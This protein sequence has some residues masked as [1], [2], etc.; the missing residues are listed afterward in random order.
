MENVSNS[1]NPLWHL[2]IV[3][4]RLQPL[5]WR[6]S[7]SASCLNEYDHIEIVYWVIFVFLLDHGPG[8]LINLPAFKCGGDSVYQRI[9]PGSMCH[10]CINHFDLFEFRA[11]WNDYS[12]NQYLTSNFNRAI[13]F[14]SPFASTM[15]K[16]SPTAFAN[17]PVHNHEGPELCKKTDLNA[18]VKTWLLIDKWISY[19]YHKKDGKQQIVPSACAT[20]IHSMYDHLVR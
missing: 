1:R 20:T 8:T 11:C 2:A 19:K 17:F 10:T 18:E 9:W 13:K 6:T 5:L 16:R 7:W 14:L 4:Y 15:A 3:P 12:V